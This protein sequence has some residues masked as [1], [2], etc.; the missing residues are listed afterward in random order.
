MRKNGLNTSAQ[1]YRIIKRS[2]HSRN[3]S[4]LLANKIESNLSKQTNPTTSHLLTQYLSVALLYSLISTLCLAAEP[5]AS[6]N[7]LPGGDFQKCAENSKGPPGWDP[8]GR[9]VKE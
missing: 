3:T 8:N 4:Y 2:T 5:T 6:P 9:V 7:L 1:S